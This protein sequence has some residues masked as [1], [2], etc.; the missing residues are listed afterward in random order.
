MDIRVSESQWWVCGARSDGLIYW[1]AAWET[2][3]YLRALKEE[4]LLDDQSVYATCVPYWFKK[5]K[6]SHMNIDNVSLEKGTGFRGE[7]ELVSKAVHADFWGLI[8]QEVKDL[9]K[10]RGELVTAKK[11][12][13]NGKAK[14]K[15]SKALIARGDKSAGKAMETEGIQQ[16]Y[17]AKLE[18]SKVES[19]MEPAE[20]S[21]R[22]WTARKC[23]EYWSAMAPTLVQGSQAG[24]GGISFTC[25][26]KEIQFIRLD[27]SPVSPVLVRTN[28]T[29]S[30]AM[31]IGT[32][33]VL[34]KVRN[35]TH[36][37]RLNDA[38]SPGQPVYLL[39]TDPM[40]FWL[41]G[42]GL[43][44][45][46]ML[47]AKNKDT[48]TEVGGQFTLKG[49]DFSS[50]WNLAFSSTF[51]NGGAFGGG[52]FFA[53][54]GPDE[55]P[56]VLIMSLDPSAA[57]PQGATLE[58]V[59]QA[60][61]FDTSALHPLA[62]EFNLALLNSPTVRNAVWFSPT[63][64]N[65]TFL[66][67]EFEMDSTGQSTIEAFLHIFIKQLSIVGLP[68]VIGKKKM[69]QIS[70]AG[71]P[72]IQTRIDSELIFEC[73]VATKNTQFTIILV[74]HPDSVEI[75][76]QW[77]TPDKGFS[78]GQI[79]QFLQEVINVDTGQMPDVSSNMPAWLSDITLREIVLTI[80]DSK[81]S[82]FNI[83]FEAPVDALNPPP[84]PKGVKEQVSFLLAYRYPQ[85]IFSVTLMTPTSSSDPPGAPALGLI[86]E[87]EK[88]LDIPIQSI[89]SGY[90]LASSVPLLKLIDWAEVLQQPH[91]ITLDVYMLDLEFSSQFISFSGAMA[92][93]TD[94]FAADVPPLV[95]SSVQLYVEYLFATKAFTLR[96]DTT[97]TLHPQDDAEAADGKLFDPVLLTGSFDYSESKWTLSMT[98]DE[99]NIAALHSL[100]DPE[101]SASMMSIL[102]EITIRY[103]SHLSPPFPKPQL[104]RPGTYP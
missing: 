73:A 44:G 16:I 50:E 85:D 97:I 84:D 63:A 66:R 103:S 64:N 74:F 57:A 11:M 101:C 31:V 98:A 48:V 37:P 3:L 34:G 49:F 2:I 18:Y 41:G 22:K 14:L 51:N 90:T 87:Y 58:T 39:D 10:H 60:F 45:T 92:C 68:R 36:L 26:N 89:I 86:P 71:E 53:E 4:N 13:V 5:A 52:V 47:M 25:N 30:T 104:I 35:T 29:N 70:V 55:G 82:E 88:Y 15:R 91:G 79:P 42:P 46:K 33:P 77:D 9:I 96:M 40:A 93:D 75:R 95:A 78:I 65:T 27:W 6:H 7:V 32:T 54:N 21:L 94:A 67:L 99:L 72:N 56:S 43:A 102:Q 19:K 8:G 76:L 83:S 12:Q 61:Q 20:A 69:T 1:C 38:P 80:S 24:P 28:A 17:A 59:A 81:I 100:M 62:G 23:T